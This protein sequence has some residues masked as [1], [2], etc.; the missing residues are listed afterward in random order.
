MFAVMLFIL[1]TIQT[2]NASIEM[3]EIVQDVNYQH[4]IIETLKIETEQNIMLE[5]Q[6]YYLVDEKLEKNDKIF[7]K[8]NKKANIEYIEALILEQGL[9]IGDGLRST[10]QRLYYKVLQTRLLRNSMTPYVYIILFLIL[11]YIRISFITRIL[12]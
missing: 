9:E 10:A 1:V 8:Q 11:I 4:N 3:K 6:L 2:T 7:D 5:K 12:W